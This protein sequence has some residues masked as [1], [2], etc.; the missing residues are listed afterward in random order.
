M[1]GRLHIADLALNSLVPSLRRDQ[2]LRTSPN[3]APRHPLSAIRLESG[4][5]YLATLFW[6][7]TPPWLKVLD[8]APHCARAESLDER[9]MFRDAFAARRCVVPASGVYAWR[10]QPRMK[11]PFLITRADRG[12]LLLAALWCRYHTTLTTWTDSTALITVAT[13]PLLS[14][15][16]DRLPALI[17]AADLAAWLDPATPLTTARAL[18]KPAPAELL[19]AFPVSRQVN[20]PSNQDWACGR[21]TGRMLRWDPEQE[22]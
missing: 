4:E 12:P 3:R 20:D 8:H 14:P 10:P 17:A 18:L 6:G 15:L 21:P 5:P 7:L 22:R 19:G 2:P 1:A 9:P 13:S 11:Q 16:T